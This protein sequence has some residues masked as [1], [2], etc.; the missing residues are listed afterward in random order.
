MKRRVE[1]S[2]RRYRRRG[3]A[4]IGVEI[5]RPAAART[6][7][8]AYGE[9]TQSVGSILGNS[10]FQSYA[11]SSGQ[12]PTDDTYPARSMIMRPQALIMFRSVATRSRNSSCA[13]ESAAELITIGQSRHSAR[14]S[15]ISAFAKT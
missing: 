13:F 10:V 15:A 2:R 6:R 5:R 8:S 3:A 4:F 11:Y 14:R 9:K 1:L 12:N 7:S